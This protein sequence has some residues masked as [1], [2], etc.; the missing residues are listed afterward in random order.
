MAAPAE[1]LQVVEVE[2]EM[3]VR[4]DR[5]AVVYLKPA[6]SAALDAAEAVTLESRN[7]QCRPSF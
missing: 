3:L 2:G 1:R 5:K 6:A 7:P 4:P